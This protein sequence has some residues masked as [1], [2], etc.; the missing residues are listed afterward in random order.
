VKSMADSQLAPHLRDWRAAPALRRVMID[1]GFLLFERYAHWLAEADDAPSATSDLLTFWDER[2][3]EIMSCMSLTPREWRRD[4]PAGSYKSQ[5]IDA[6][7][8]RL[9]V[10]RNDGSYYI[11][12]KIEEKMVLTGRFPKI[13]ECS[14]IIKRQ[15]FGVGLDV[16][17]IL[18]SDNLDIARLLTSAAEGYG[19]SFWKTSARWRDDMGDLHSGIYAKEFG[20]L[21]FSI[22]YMKQTWGR[23]R[24]PAGVLPFVC[25]ISL[26]DNPDDSFW[27]GDMG[28][29]CPEASL[30]CQYTSPTSAIW[31][32][33]AAVALL[34]AMALS[35]Q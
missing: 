10:K 31:G 13:L 21:R 25:A 15:E 7:F 3:H 33:N 35:F 23:A 5:Y 17:P 22:G 27:I 14:E 24:L 1:R 29:I 19:F 2:A 12:H 16:P 9:S 4:F 11:R 20:D 32:F 34:D 30:Y 8:E 28:A 6:N 26:I 18:K